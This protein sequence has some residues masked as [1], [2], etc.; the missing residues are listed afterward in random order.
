MDTGLPGCLHA[1]LQG[2]PEILPR[3]R[4][5]SPY[6]GKFRH[7][8]SA[9][10]IS[11]GT[12]A[13][14]RRLAVNSPWRTTVATRDMQHDIVKQL[15]YRLLDRLGVVCVCRCPLRDHPADQRYTCCN[16]KCDSYRPRM[17]P[18]HGG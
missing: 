18:V 15:A 12:K 13:I 2:L 16:C 4:Q 1:T 6:G 14:T 10:Q 5:M 3:Q 8:R 9:R 11:G 7:P 17:R